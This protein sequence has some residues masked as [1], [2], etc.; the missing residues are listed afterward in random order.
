MSYLSD[1]FGG[2]DRQ[3]DLDAAMKLSI[4]EVLLN[5]QF[6]NLKWLLTDRHEI[7]GLEGDPGWT[8]ERRDTV[9]SGNNQYVSDWPEGARFRA[10]VDPEIFELAHSEFFMDEATF[11]LYVAAGMQAYLKEN[12][13]EFDS[14]REII[15]RVKV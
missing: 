6:E 15:E 12:P 2:F 5:R 11:H 14:V 7:G 4:N 8:I 10:Y 9:A 3:K 1:A 13:S